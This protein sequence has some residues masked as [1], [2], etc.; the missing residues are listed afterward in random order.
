MIPSLST[1]LQQRRKPLHD[2]SN[3][4]QVSSELPVSLQALA[5]RD[6]ATAPAPVPAAL[7]PAPSLTRVVV[8]APVRAAVSV[9]RA[10]F[11]GRPVAV[12]RPMPMATAA[13]SARAVQPALPAG[14][15]PSQA[16]ALVVWLLLVLIDGGLS[17]HSLLRSPAAAATSF[18]SGRRAAGRAPA[19]ASGRR[20][21]L[22]VIAADQ[23]AVAIS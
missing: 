14:G 1:R 15:P 3:S 12:G 19:A 13:P 8:A 20:S 6:A 21:L 5:A 10:G 22:R 11:A 9:G 4:W 7:E 23:P 18:Q 2:R 16:I 17:L